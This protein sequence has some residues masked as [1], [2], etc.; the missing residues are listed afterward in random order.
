MRYV[1]VLATLCFLGF[2][3]LLTG[4]GPTAVIY[5]VDLLMGNDDTHNGLSRAQSFQTIQTGI[6]AACDGDEVLVWPGIYDEELDF[7]GKKITVQSAADAATLSPSTP[8]AF[9]VSFFTGED[10]SSVLKNFIIRDCTKGVFLV[11][12]SP[13]LEHLTIVNTNKAVSSG[14]GALPVLVS[15][16]IWNNANKNLEDVQVTYSCVEEETPGIGNFSHDPL[17]V[18]SINGDYHLRSEFGRYQPDPNDP[19][20]IEGLWLTDSE[21]SPCID[22]GD[23]NSHPAPELQPSGGRVN[24]GAYGQTPYAAKSINPWPNAADLNRDG[25]VSLLDLR[26]LADQWL[27]TIVEGLEASADFDDNGRVDVYDYAILNRE[28]LWKAP[29]IN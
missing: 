8:G 10:H 5:H 9:A 17:F 25:L 6:D 18:N 16:I 15:S 29:F 1:V 20:S 26:L 11:G 2:G 19:N 23:P 3:D 24:A 13:V 4:A 12:T 14:F 27:G 22:A 28:W 7:L 21:T